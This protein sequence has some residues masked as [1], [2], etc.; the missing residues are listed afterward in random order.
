MPIKNKHVSARQAAV[1]ILL[2]VLKEGAYT[3]IAINKYLRSHEMPD[4]DRRLLTELVYGSIKALGTIDWYLT[5]CVT[6]PLA[7]IDAP[8]L[9]ILRLSVYQ[10][11][12]MDKNFMHEFNTNRM[13]YQYNQ[14]FVNKKYEYTVVHKNIDE[15]TKKNIEK[16]SSKNLKIKFYNISEYLDKTNPNF[17]YDKR[18]G[19]AMFYRIFAPDIF[20]EYDKILYLDID[21]TIFEDIANL[22]NIDINNYEL[23]VSKDFFI[24][25]Y[26]TTNEYSHKYKKH[27]KF[28][29]F[30]LSNLIRHLVF[31]PIP[32]Y[33]FC[34]KTL[35]LTWQPQTKRAASDMLAQR[36]SQPRMP[37]DE[38]WLL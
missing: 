2:Q 33:I 23:A 14:D 19:N 22:Y 37:R 30:N 17:P 8:I 4:L 10:I 21:L 18:R 32:F 6:R 3:N 9:N 31:Q 25:H 38:I 16:L 13:K 7:K 5:Q 1:E 15:Q 36:T 12:Y 35:P 28:F 26:N 34:Q 24:I 20:P 29:S 27:L 11:L